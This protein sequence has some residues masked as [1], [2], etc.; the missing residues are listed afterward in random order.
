[1]SI[2][3]EALREAF[4]SWANT[5]WAQGLDT[6]YMAEYGAYVDE[7]VQ[8]AWKAFVAAHKLTLNSLCVGVDCLDEDG[9]TIS[10]MSRVGDITTVLA[11]GHT[12][13]GKSNAFM[14][15]L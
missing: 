9:A 7:A 15:D 3:N 1:M 13:A 8:T 12:K 2:N 11:C 14:V 10:L 5:Y 4:E 6:E